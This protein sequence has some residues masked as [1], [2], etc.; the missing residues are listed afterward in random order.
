MAAQVLGGTGNVSYTNSTGQNVR[1]VINY[2]KCGPSPTMTINT[3]G[4][5]ITPDLE[6]EAVYGKSIAYSAKEGTGTH[7]SYVYP[8]VGSGGAE[9]IPIE[10]GLAN[11]G[12]F[13]ITG[14]TNQ[15]NIVIIPEAG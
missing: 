12:T 5:S 14:S 15:Y 13:S 6:T 4:A 8:R 7:G 3:G 9:G 1:V 2:L 11:G 10:F